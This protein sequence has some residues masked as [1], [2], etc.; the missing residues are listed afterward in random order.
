[1]NI[2]SY[3]TFSGNCRQ[4][5]TFYQ[6]SLGGELSLQ[7]VGES[8]MAAKMPKH[9]QS[10]ILHAT[11]TSGSLVLMGSDMVGEAGLNRGNGVAMMLHC[12]SEA[13]LRACYQK[14]AHGGTK[15]NPLELTFW[16]ALF[17]DLTD[18]FGNQWLLHFQAR[19]ACG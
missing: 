7:T 5:M 12:D 9:L 16:G 6:Q 19:E 18:Q 13:E 15:T 4:A 17:G 2:N 10:C 14:L 3:L 11:L 1:M 8:P